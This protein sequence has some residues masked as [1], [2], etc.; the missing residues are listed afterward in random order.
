M[1]YQLVLADIDGTLLNDEKVLLPSTEQTIHDL[2]K[3]GVLFATVSARTIPYTESGISTLKDVCSA[4]AY[5]NGAFVVT[6]K[7]EVLVDRF[8][9]KE[10]ASY[11]VELCNE[12]RASFLCVSKDNALGKIIHPGFEMPFK[13]HHGTFSEVPMDAKS[14]LKVY[15][16]P[17]ISEDIGSVVEIVTNKLPNIEAGPIR[18]LPGGPGVT[19]LQKKGTN[20]AKALRSIAEYYD[21]DL[22]KTLAFG[23][24]VLN[25][26]PM[27]EEAG[28]G[29]AMKN[30]NKALVDRAKYVTKKD[31]NE[32]GVGDFLRSMMW[33]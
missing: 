27:I 12:M 15:L 1:H 8:F 7:G 9:D 3:S 20:K 17:V 2:V 23:D 29:V 33:R 11:L 19:F 31:N 30:A 26:R 24:D 5:V 14:Q 32:D 6:S 10:E 22:S 16:M 28:C 13:Q 21:V 18:N 25:D 4:N